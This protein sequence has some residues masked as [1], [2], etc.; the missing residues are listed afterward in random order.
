[1]AAYLYTNAE[2]NVIPLAPIHFQ[3]GHEFISLPEVDLSHLKRNHL[4]RWKYIQ[5]LKQ[6][7]C[8]K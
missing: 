4:S 3:I 6:E 7:F 1:M 8:K 2:D 5:S